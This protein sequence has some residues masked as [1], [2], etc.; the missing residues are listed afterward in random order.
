MLTISHVDVDPRI[1]KVTRSLAERGYSVELICYGTAPEYSEE[2][3]APRI[4]LLRVPRD[5]DWR[6]WIIY[7]PELLQPAL[8]RTFDV[9]HAND[10]TTLT[11]AWVLARRRRVPLVY[12]AHELWSENCE[13]DGSRWVPMSRRTR[14]LAG[15]WE[16]FLLRDVSV[17]ATVG[18]S[19]ALEYRRRWWRLPRPSPVLLPNYPSLKLD[20]PSPGI[21]DL[22]T[23][24]GLSDEDD[25]FITLY[26]GGVNELRNIENVIAAHAYLPENHVFVIRGPGIDVAAPGY[27][28]LAQRFGVAH[29]VFCL[30]PVGMNE[31]IAGAAGAD[32]GILMLRNICRNFYFCYPNKLFEYALA[33]IPVAVSEFPDLM[34]FVEAERCGVSFDPDS[35]QSIA[36]AIARLAAE[37]GQAR[38]MGDRARASILRERNWE[39]AFESLATAY[40]TLG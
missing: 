19:L 36:G 23:A 24:L 10:L 30:P 28:D 34:A 38:E 26:L 8:Q 15:A 33:G 40:G 13:F 22:R 16:R 9:V 32:C 21:P 6:A 12:D 31:V 7:Q 20:Q 25:R 29:R 39:A 27:R 37:R 5:H 11:L 14:V 18:P 17:M 3:I 4:R 1:H 2:E 35:P